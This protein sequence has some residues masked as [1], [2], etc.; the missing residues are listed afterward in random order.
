MVCVTTVRA[1][2]KLACV[3]PAPETVRVVPGNSLLHSKP[4]LVKA[5]R[6][7]AESKSLKSLIVRVESPRCGSTT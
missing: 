3:F 2:V 5:K 6:Y 7:S 4:L 1:K